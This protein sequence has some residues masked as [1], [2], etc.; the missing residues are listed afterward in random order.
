MSGRDLVVLGTASQ[1]PTRTRNHNGYLLRWDREGLLFDPG[2][3]TQRQFTSAGVSAGRITRILLT[4]LHGDHCLGL[5]GMLQR[6]ALDGADEEVPIHFPASGLQYVERLCDASIG[7]RAPIRLEPVDDTG[8]VIAAGP[9]QVTAL[10]LSHRVPT[11]GWRVEE[12]EA[13][14]FLP[15][16]LEA[17]G[18]HG[19]DVGRLLETGSIDVDGRRIDLSEVSEV[20][21]GRSAAVVM[22]TA[23]CDNAVRLAA[24]VDVLL[25]EATFL[26][27][28]SF[29][30]RDYGHL[31]AREAATIAREAGVGLLVLTHFSARYPDLD[32]HRRE[33]EAVFP[34]VVVAH[35]LAV[36]P[37]PERRPC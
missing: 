19:P 32:R 8:G 15:D 26:E 28:E 31:T 24:G 9:L 20:R 30:A 5:P 16:L 29:L 21:P 4:H 36:V 14:H 25:C 35:D 23:A 13:T 7:R 18:V 1:A 10:P 17:A 11:L 27:S 33:A 2:E 6:L 37:F 12:L 3:G 22:D 34:D